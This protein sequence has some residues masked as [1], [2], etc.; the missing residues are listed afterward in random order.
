MDLFTDPLDPS[1]QVHDLN[2][3]ILPNGLFWIVQVPDKSVDVNPGAGKAHFALEDF[4]IEDY[5]DLVKALADGPSVDAELSFDCRWSDGIQTRFIRNPDPLE[6]FTGMFVQTHATIAW[7]ASVPSQH[8]VF[9][10]D[11]A[12]TSHEVYAEVGEERNGFF[13]S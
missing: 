4:E 12:A 11:G 9:Q 8:F 5:H 7:S 3:G 1:T 13:F 10:S 2:P 6:R